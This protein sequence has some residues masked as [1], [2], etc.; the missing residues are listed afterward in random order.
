M[1]LL[2]WLFT[3]IA[4]TLGESCVHPTGQVGECVPIRSCPS[5]LWSF[6][7]PK[8]GVWD[9]LLKFKCSDNDDV[10]A[11][12]LV[13]C[14]TQ[15][16][17]FVFE[18]EEDNTEAGH[19]E[20]PLRLANVESC[21]TASEDVKID[22]GVARLQDFPW[23]VK[24]IAIEN[25]L[26]EPDKVST[27]ACTGVL[28]NRRN[29]IYSAQ[30]FYALLW[31]ATFMVRIDNYV[32]SDTDCDQKSYS[33]RCSDFQLYRVEVYD[34]HLFY[35]PQTKLN[36]IAMLRLHARVP[37]SDH[38]KPI[39]LPLATN[40]NLGE[41]LYTVGWNI[42]FNISDVSV[43]RAYV[44]KYI[45]NEECEKTQSVSVYE[46]CTEADDK[47]LDEDRAIGLPLMAFQND[48]W[49]LYGFETQ[50]KSTKI[51][52]RLQNYWQWMQG[53]TGGGNYPINTKTLIKI[54]ERCRTPDNEMGESMHPTECDR[55]MDAF[56]NASPNEEDALKKFGLTSDFD[57][58]DDP[59][60]VCCGLEPNFTISLPE[61]ENVDLE[62][63]NFA[64]C[65]LQHRDDYVFDSDEVSVDEFPWLAVILDGN[66]PDLDGAVCGGSLITHRYVLSSAQC[67]TYY[68]LPET[69]VPRLIVRLG[70]YKAAN[71]SNCVHFD[72]DLYDCNEVQ[73]YVVEENII[74]PFYSAFDNTNDIALL[75]L[76]RSVEFS[77]YVRPICLPRSEQDVALEEETLFITGFGR[78]EEEL[79]IHVKKKIRA[80]LIPIESCRDK[81][82]TEEF[83]NST[84]V[85]CVGGEG[86]PVMFSR[87]LRWFIEGITT[88][89]QCGR[90]YPTSYLRV[91]KYL[92]WIKTHMKP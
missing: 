60:K 43:K 69:Y 83:E 9:E 73:E 72:Q 7:N 37:F 58:P 23:L 24:L 64:Y 76:Q 55:L 91:Y 34:L 56:A 30:C 75:R 11:P 65:G 50:G 5:L 17:M 42:T 12:L 80:T 52:T 85:A 41:T 13:C 19:S 66:L 87:K 45:S 71:K 46:I 3:L 74:H 25:Y 32:G 38:M 22:D 28:I 33:P 77:D 78:R 15:D 31:N 57:E 48:R 29:V 49:Y 53:V 67:M 40:L 70:H 79:F 27:V 81:R 62:I 36:D 26:D 84:D 6:T 61:S 10:D 89:Y 44:S 8:F 35:D 92:R 4:K 59:L 86:G 51:H 18:N 14:R 39:C 47:K 82:C 88:N 21:G 54:S 68:K 90:P 20:G 16:D 1:Y 63:S 2:L